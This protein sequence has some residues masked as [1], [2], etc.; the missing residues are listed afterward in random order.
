MRT[1]TITLYRF[2]ELPTDAAK[3]RAR[4]WWRSIMDFDG[5]DELDSIKTFCDYFGVKLTD[6]SIGPYCAI[7]YRT[8]AANH[9]FRSHKLRE[10]S[11]E[12]MPTGY[13]LDC[14]LWMTFYDVFKKTGDAKDAFDSALWEAF[15]DWRTDMEWHLSD[16]S[17]DESLTMNE[18]EFHENGSRA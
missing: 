7:E 1:E 3:E 16:E 4:E 11:R 10:F 12:H 9:H 17:I 13:Y 8:D 2:D 5:R 14:S 18:Y 15:K 6:W